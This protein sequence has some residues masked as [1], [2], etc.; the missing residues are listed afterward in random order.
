MVDKTARRGVST[1]DLTRWTTPVSSALQHFELYWT[2]LTDA[3]RE[4]IV[5]AGLSTI[6]TVI[7][8]RV[9]VPFGG[10]RI[11]ANTWNVLLGPSSTYRKSTVV[12]FARRT[13]ARLTDG[14]PDEY[15]FPDE[16]SK[17]ALVSRLGERAQG[18]LTYREFSGALAGFSR[19]Y[20][21]G[22][23]ELLADLYDCP[24]K[25][26]RV[27]GQKTITA[28]NVCLSILAASQTD[29]LL[30]KIHENDLRGGFLARFTFWPAFYKRRFLAIPPEPDTQVGNELVRH[31]NT[32]RRLEG[33]MRLPLDVR[34][35]YATWLQGHEHQL[36]SLPRAGQLG[37]FWSRMGITTLKLALVLQVATFGTLV[38]ND[39]AL[40]SAIE[41][42]E[43]LKLA[44]AKLFD[45][46]IAFTPAMKDRQKILRLITKR[47][48]LSYRDL[49][50]ASSLTK[51][52]LD[53]VL[54]TLIC[55]GTVRR[56]KDAIYLSAASAPVSD[57]PTD[58]VGP[59]FVRV[60]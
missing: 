53:P 11:Y 1:P 2:P 21:S 3:P 27:V 39:Q 12:K 47:S 48:G 43:Y 57:R 15:L 18:L 16:F 40:T 33:A 31:L 14:Q 51:K 49:L 60:K 10:D 54:E 25:Y 28:T 24:D 4:Y 58:K 5:P 8:N 23:K 26:E 37:P 55:E 34:D 56:E 6:G 30:E 36:D 20:M 45:E 7:A 38:M 32:I 19:D 52:Q 59:M 46:E 17:E 44:L 42:T 41:L 29:W 13:L 9:Y 22:T 35:H 50:R